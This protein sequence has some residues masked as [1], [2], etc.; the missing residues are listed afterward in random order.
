MFDLLENWGLTLVIGWGRP[1]HW[2]RK[3]LG[4]GSAPLKQ[5]R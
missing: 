2:W 1:P 3:I 4:W 5:D